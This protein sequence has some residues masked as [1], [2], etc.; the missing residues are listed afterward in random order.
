M[1]GFEV[2]TLLHYISVGFL[3]SA[4]M[5]CEVQSCKKLRVYIISRDN[6]YF[7]VKDSQANLFQEDA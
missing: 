5:Q 7:S 6:I 3:N 4:H 1:T 2:K